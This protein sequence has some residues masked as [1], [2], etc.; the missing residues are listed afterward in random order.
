VLLGGGGH[1]RVIIEILRESRVATPVAILDRDAAL[2]GTDV[3]GVPVWG[4]D[5][6]LAD[7]V[8]NTIRTFVVGVGGVGDNRP[9]R[10][11]WELGLRHGLVGLTVRHPSAVCSPTAD[12]GA[13]TVLFPQAVVNAGARLGVN[14]IVN[15]A[16]V[17][18]HDCDVGDHAHVA[19]GARLCSTV[20]VGVGAHVGAGA[21]VRQRLRIGE[22]AVIGAGAVVVTDVPADTVVVGVPARPL[23]RRASR[24]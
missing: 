16:A 18:E 5:D 7:V 22:R 24:R 21:T 23:A 11:L 1:A 3:L 9:R 17:V 10:R 20:R 6:R 15:T 8:K 14:V 2:W 12:L 19:T 13:G 4:G